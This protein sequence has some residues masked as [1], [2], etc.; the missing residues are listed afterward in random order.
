MASQKNKS[1]KTVRQV[2]PPTATQQRSS[3]DAESK[4]KRGLVDIPELSRQLIQC[5]RQTGGRL[6]I[7]DAVAATGAS[8]NTIKAHLKQ[9]VA[10][11]RLV[12][13]GT[14]RG[15]WYEPRDS[16]QVLQQRSAHFINVPIAKIQSL[17]SEK[18]TELIKEILRAEVRYC[19]LP[20]TSL[21]IS[22]RITVP[23]GGIDATV[24]CGSALPPQ[25]SLISVRLT[26][27]QVKAGSSFAPWRSREIRGELLK[28]GA[29]KP[30]IQSLFNRGGRYLLICTGPEFTPQQRD[31]AIQSIAEVIA[32]SGTS[33]AI[34]QIDVI[35][36]NDLGELIERYPSLA[37]QYAEMP[38]IE[39]ATVDEWSRSAHMSN[40]FIP[41]D[42][43]T[44]L[45]ER[46]RRFCNSEAKHLRILGEP[47]LG[48]TRC[49]LEA[50]QDINL[51]NLVLYFEHGASFG[52]SALFKW[53]LKNQPHHPLIV[54]LDDLSTRE[55]RDVWNHLKS[56]TG[57]VK[58]ITLDHGTDDYEDEDI[59][60][61]NAPLLPNNA[62]ED[63]L[64]SVAGNSRDVDRWVALC[65]GSP[66]V[67]LAI[68]EN[69][70]QNTD[71]PLKPPSTVDVWKRFI[72]GSSKIETTET[73]QLDCVVHHLA[74]F[75]RF[76]FEEPV[77]DEALYISR[78][79]S[80]VDTSIGWHRFQEIVRSLRQRRVLQGKT[81]LFFVPKALHVFLW[82]EYW[83]TYGREFDFRKILDEMPESLQVWFMSMFSYAGG[84]AAS[85]AIK[86]ILKLD[87]AYADR[88]FFSS[89]KGSRFLAN[90]A[91]ANPAAVLELIERTLN[92]WTTTDLRQFEKH[93]QN[94]VWTLEKIAVWTDYTV[95]ACRILG[96]LAVAENANNSNN[97]TG[98]LVSLFGIGPE[99][100]ATEAPPEKRL[101]YLIELLSAPTDEERLLGLKCATNAVRTTGGGL[102]IVGPEYQ[103]LKAR[104]KLWIPRTWGEL[105]S[106]KEVYFKALTEHTEAWPTNLQPAACRAKVE[107]CKQFLMAGINKELA[108]DELK[109]VMQDIHADPSQL[110]AFFRDWRD[111][112]ANEQNAILTSE[113]E[114][115][116]RQFNK[117]S[118]ASRIQRYVLDV[119]WMEWD[120]SLRD[121][122]G[123]PR[124]RAKALVGALARRAMK[125][126]DQ[127]NSH[128]SLLFAR[129]TGPALWQFGNELASHDPRRTMLE[130]LLRQ[131][132][133]CDTWIC[134]AGYV[135]R[136]ESTDLPAYRKLLLRLLDNIESSPLG[137]G[138]C[139][140]GGYD[141]ALFDQCLT[142][143]AR[144]WISPRLFSSLT[145]GGSWK[146]LPKASLRA[147]V[148]VLESSPDDDATATLV[149]ILYVLP[150]DED[151]PFTPDLVFNVICRAC[152]SNTSSSTMGGHYWHEV[153]QK[154]IAW[155]PEYSRRLLE[156][157]IAQMHADYAKSY[158]HDVAPL[159]TEILS[160][161]PL[162]AW[163]VASFQIEAVLPNWDSGVMHWLK[164]GIGG[165][166]EDPPV[167]PISSVPVET[168]LAWI[169]TD[170]EQRAA[171]VAHMAPRSLD[172][173]TGGELT[174]AL[175]THYGNVDGVKSGISSIFGS[176][177]WAGNES[178]YLRKRRDKFRG[179]LGQGFSLEV[180]TWVEEQLGY[181]DKRIE[182]AEIDEERSFFSR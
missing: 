22:S 174:R 86:N 152:V 64:R 16:I 72:R 48:K 79:I 44:Q 87:G 91:E 108:L 102:R 107:A 2:P 111:Y 74:L 164:G 49:T 84:T 116:A 173:V 63:I 105:W 136:I 29:L 167:S 113:V 54:V 92:S 35:D 50:L 31:K 141:A 153:C 46:I 88:D 146:Q 176:G 80:S 1:A 26:G 140:R 83:G 12:L 66:R 81:T 59:E 182:R 94:L 168:V 151:A 165:F 8:R 138:L 162:M 45:V 38:F 103:G 32:D 158:D 82:R 157:L 9:L 23:D 177:G 160:A 180:E 95:R 126:T 42:T 76:G 61:V 149:E 154:L 33:V 142:V 5:A 161:D 70:R 169:A 124:Y 121:R 115:L 39:A 109:R 57:T 128:L 139:L 144:R 85:G 53:L 148:D 68:A 143:L 155:R 34:G 73:R 11:E 118:L 65:E 18:A 19:E 99:V 20:P 7:S 40:G 51:R 131:S 4:G 117:R 71:D 172:N 47:G 106:A 15:A 135:S 37:Q 166:G 21:T 43:Q 134:F 10:E 58:L 100:A 62:I 112:R 110:N 123:K 52:N 90:L 41:T 14:G 89:A 25:D 175:L 119:D 24:D 6:T 150:Y 97:A 181:I 78:W 132:L 56:R 120:E 75:G 171:V 178:D 163:E 129:S 159:A 30:A 67:A 127:L 28:N 27:M 179:W 137:A 60:Q 130:P 114:K 77:G 3:T 36:A 93:R 170:A 55:L 133:S 17:T 145:F 125:D 101:P 147:L 122:T 156:Q 98:T 104:A 69:I 96:R 13:R